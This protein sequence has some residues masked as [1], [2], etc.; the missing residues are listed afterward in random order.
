MKKRKRQAFLIADLPKWAEFSVSGTYHGRHYTFYKVTDE[1]VDY[2]YHVGTKE[3]QY[4]PGAVV[5][6]EFKVFPARKNWS[7][8]KDTQKYWIVV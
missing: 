4:Q 1:N 8:R 6:A 3:R 7:H 5:V 2:I